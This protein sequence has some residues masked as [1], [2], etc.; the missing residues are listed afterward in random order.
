MKTYAENIEKESFCRKYRWKNFAENIEKE[1]YAESIE[2]ESF[3]E[4]IL[5]NICLYA[6]IEIQ[7]QTNVCGSR[8]KHCI[9]II[10]YV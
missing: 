4:N 5:T 3:A 7:K 9:F 6:M 2:W 1:N 8:R 10:W